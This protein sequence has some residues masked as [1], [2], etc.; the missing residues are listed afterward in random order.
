M[1]NLVKLFFHLQNVII[2]IS[3]ISEDICEDKKKIDNSETLWH[4]VFSLHMDSIVN[5]DH[6]NKKFIKTQVYFSYL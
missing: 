2:K 5:L 3:T 1:T 6:K 4:M